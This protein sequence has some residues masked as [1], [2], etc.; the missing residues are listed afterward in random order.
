[1]V[2]GYLPAFSPVALQGLANVSSSTVPAN[3]DVLVWSTASSEW[4]PGAA[5]SP[6][7]ALKNKYS[8]TVDPTVNDDADDSYD[9]GSSW[10]N[11]NTERAYVCLDTTVGAAVWKEVTPM[12]Q[13]NLS[14]ASAPTT[15][16]DSDDGYAVG[17]VWVDTTADVAYI[18]TDPS[19]GA[20]VWE[21]ITPE[22]LSNLAASTAPSV[23][24]D[25]SGGYRPGSIWA[26]TTA[27]E[28]YVCV[29]ASV[30][31]AV[32]VKI[33]GGSTA[34]NNYAAV[35][36]PTVNDDS[37]SG[38]GVGSMWINTSNGLIFACTDASV[39]AAVWSNLNPQLEGFVAARTSTQTYSSGAVSTM[40]NYAAPRFTVGSASAFDNSTGVYT[41]PSDGQY[42]V[43][44]TGFFAPIGAVVSGSES[45][46]SVYDGTTE[47]PITLKHTST[48]SLAFGIPSGSTVFDLSTSDTVYTRIYQSTGVDITAVATDDAC[49]FGMMKLR[50]M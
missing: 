42:F 27:D 36:D 32:W 40:T 21:I 17:S 38:Y 7:G 5:P 49:T 29:D 23:N 9:V 10:V 26:D 34:Q 11:T 41:V 12:A 45:S 50:V 3:G 33:T 16:D 25:S 6:S 15:G 4:V 35:A 24:D 46:M 30:G 18:C 1:M 43:F 44:L 37:G 39:G 8:A 19:V 20:A 47:V 14:A 13:A 48:T 31:A 28:A 22:T 2:F